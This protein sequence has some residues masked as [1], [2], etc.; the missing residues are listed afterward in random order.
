ME[1]SGSLL[2]VHAACL[3][4]RRELIALASQSLRGSLDVSFAAAPRL[5]GVVHLNQ[6]LRQADALSHEL[7]H[8]PVQAFILL[9]QEL[10]L[11]LVPAHLLV[12]LLRALPV[13]DVVAAARLLLLPLRRDLFRQF[14]YVILRGLNLGLRLGASLLLLA[15][16]ALGALE[17]LAH[18]VELGGEVAEP[19]LGGFRLKPGVFDVA[20]ESSVGSASALELH[21][22]EFFLHH[23]QVAVALPHRV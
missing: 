7:L 10:V 16:V 11:L 9:R 6:R 8:A 13:G 4:L 22:L 1:Q 15:D 17:L 20:C 14:S 2:E 23:V 5:R 19:A 21:L 12:T 3:E 18:D